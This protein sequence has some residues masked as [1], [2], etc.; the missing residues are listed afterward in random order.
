[1]QPVRVQRN[2]AIFFPLRFPIFRRSIAMFPGIANLQSV[3][4]AILLSRKECSGQ[5]TCVLAEERIHIC[6]LSSHNSARKKHPETHQSSPHLRWSEHE[7]FERVDKKPGLPN[8]PLQAKVS[9]T[10]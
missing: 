6:T 3:T 4:W 7:R 8:V 9:K 10:E 1:M 5:G 2:F